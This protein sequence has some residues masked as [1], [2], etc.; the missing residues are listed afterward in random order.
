MALT[1]EETFALIGDAVFRGRVS[2]ACVHYADYITTETPTTPAHSTRY[3]WA[4]N[5]LVAP[6]IAVSQ[7]INTVV[8]DTAVQADGAAIT[9]AALQSVVETS[10]NKLL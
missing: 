2:V 8:N 3:K 10:V 1:Y 6:D 7:V 9:D 5:T 4:Q